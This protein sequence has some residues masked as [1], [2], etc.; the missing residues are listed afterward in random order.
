MYAQYHTLTGMAWHRTGL[1]VADQITLR[2]SAPDALRPQMV[3]LYYQ[4]FQQKLDVVFDSWECA[5]DLLEQA[6][7]PDLA[8]VAQYQHQVMGFAGLAYGDRRFVDLKP[9]PLVREFGLVRGLKKFA[10]LAALDSAP[11]RDEVLVESLAVRPEMRG[12]GIGSR[13]LDAVCAFA[14]KNGFASVGLEVVDTNPSA[15]RLYERVGFVPVKTRTCSLL[16]RAMDLGSV[17]KME[18]HKLE[19]GGM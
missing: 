4:T 14:R 11:R 7:K 17:I 15:R 13:L 19:Q 12:Q 5:M 9:T 8:I 18:K 10:R 2:M 3:A 1:S 16:G 6:L